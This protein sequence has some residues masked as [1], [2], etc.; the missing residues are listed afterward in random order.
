MVG[1]W[2]AV[3]VAIVL[4]FQNEL[5]MFDI[6]CG[7]TVDLWGHL[8]ID[9]LYRETVYT[10]PT[11][12]SLSKA[13]SAAPVGTDFEKLHDGGL[14]VSAPWATFQRLSGGELAWP[15]WGRLPT[16]LRG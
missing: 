9:V 11:A 14:A 3:G 15:Y 12:A 5:D 2:N 8:V 1:V 6:M 4:L 10:F 7:L 13:R 16:I